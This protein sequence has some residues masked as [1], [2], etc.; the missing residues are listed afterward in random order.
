[1]K[2]KIIVA[3]DGPSGCGKSST[4][5]IV[6]KRLKYVYVDT[7]AMYR[8][9]TLHFIDENVDLKDNTNIQKALSE[10]EID[11]QFNQNLQQ[12]ETCLNGKNVEDKIRTLAVSDNVSEVSAIPEVRKKMVALQRKMGEKKGLVMDGRDI[13][14]V[15]FPNAELK[16]YMTADPEI[17]AQRR[18]KELK[19][20]GINA[21]F[22]EVLLNLQKRDKLDSSRTDSPLT[23]ASDAILLDTSDLNFEDQ[24]EIIVNLALNKISEI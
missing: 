23:Q 15:V 2:E 1:M 3:I 24:V 12:S 9:A 7:G 8:A 10:I 16:I 13:G 4:A 20:K 11:F 17:R 14:T 21:N 19:E 5:K 22:K 6:S 18:L